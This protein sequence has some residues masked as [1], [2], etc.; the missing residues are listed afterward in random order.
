MHFSTRRASKSS[1]FSYNHP[2]KTLTAKEAK[3]RLGQA[4]DMAL[5]EAVLITKNGR[6]SVVLVSA[7]RYHELIHAHETG[8]A[9]VVKGQSAAWKSRG[10]RDL[11]AQVKRGAAKSTDASVF[12]RLGA[13]AKVRFG[14]EEF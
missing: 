14:N 5:A 11:A 7:E 4:I 8:R 13:T 6:E 3:N 9:E 10:R 1:Y 2:M 12:F